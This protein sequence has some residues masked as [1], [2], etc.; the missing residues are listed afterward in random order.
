MKSLTINLDAIEIKP[1]TNQADFERASALIDALID[2]D[3]I[4]DEATRNKAL[5]ILDAISVL[6]LDYEKKHFPI[7]K[8]DPIESIKQRIEMLNLSQ[9]EVAKYFG[10]ENRVSEVLNRKRPLTLKMVKNLYHG[11]GIPAEVL[12][13]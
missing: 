6:A 3:L 4:E 11:L 5:D 7:E 9:K 8:L 13:A 10:G 2:A 12:L 1:I